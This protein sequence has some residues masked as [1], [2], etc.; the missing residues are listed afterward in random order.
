MAPRII[1][2][3]V[4]G[5][6]AGVDPNRIYGTHWDADHT[7]LGLTIGTDVQPHDATLDGL[8][9]MDTTAGVVVETATGIFAKRTITGTTNEITVT[10]GNGV[11]SNPT[12]SLPAAITTTGKTITGG[13]YN[14]LTITSST[15]NGNTWTAG[16]GTLTLGVGKT[17]NISNTLTFTGTDGSSAAF[18]AGGTVAYTANKLSAFAA[19]TSAE[20][21]GVISDK[22]GTGA[23]VFAA[24]PILMIPN[25]GTPS[26]V[27][28]TNATGL[29]IS[30]GVSGLATGVATFLTTPSSANLNAALTNKTGS[31]A[32]VFATSPM[33]VTPDLGTPTSATLTNATGLPVSTGVSGLGTNVAIFL[34]TPSSANLA[35]ALT[36]KT[37]TG[38]AVFSASPMLVT[39]DL[40]TPSAAIL[41]NATGL[42][43]AGLTTQGAYTIVANATGS[44]AVPTAMDV[45]ALTAKASPVSADIILIQDSAAANAFKRTTVGALTTAGSVS[46]FNGR[47]GAVTAIST[48]VPLRSYL[49][50][51]TLSA[52]GSTATFGIAVG[53]ATD[54]TNTAMMAIASA[55]TKTTSSWAVGSANGALDTGSIANSTWYHVYLIKRTDTGV[56]DILVSLSASAPTMPTNYTLFRRIGSMRT[57]GSAQWIKFVQLGDEFLWAVPT[58]D[59]NVS[60]LGTVATLYTLT[61][62]TGVQVNALVRMNGTNATVGTAILFNSPDEDVSAAAAPNG[63]YNILVFQSG[64]ANT[65]TLNLRTN[66]SA[67][68]RGV[69]NVASTT[70]QASTYGWTEMRGKNN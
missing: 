6:P 14:G 1:H 55:Y 51:L 61:V 8:V 32:A 27:T 13:T 58:S 44:S 57:N 49:S 25:L 40:G 19:T 47:T 45:T 10:N 63:N 2:T 43:L 39:P 46:S 29:P 42:P 66:T 24:N 23:L 62:P 11:S 36:G 12:V 41:T 59:I 38:V 30:T 33:L 37:G 22:T 67:Q 20:L 64:T 35:T 17:A 69:A 65:T 3:K 54:S 21:A 4:S 56:V 52:A 16:T 31:G 48:D 70:V 9:A 28:L 26:A 60:N 5:K 18:G 34:A 7:I 50:G 15:Y 68:L 53:V